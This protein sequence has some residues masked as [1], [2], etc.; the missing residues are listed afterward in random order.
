MKNKL[1]IRAKS[2]ELDLA[3]ETDF[4]FR[5][6]DAIKPVLMERFVESID[7][8][9]AAVDPEIPSK[10]SV[11][12]TAQLHGVRTGEKATDAAPQEQASHFNLV[13]CN[14]VYNKVYLVDREVLAD[15]IFGESLD[16]RQVTRV[17]INR[18]QVDQF[19]EH[20]PSGKVLWREL[21]TEGKRAVKNR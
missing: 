13:V 9:L 6:Y 21:T 16:E 10:R 5:A 19:E 1:H 4:V 8:T 14:R 3:G 12:S 2:L 15:G 7:L 17:F 18:S 11:R 20:L